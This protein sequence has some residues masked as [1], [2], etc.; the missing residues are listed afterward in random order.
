MRGGGGASFTT[1]DSLVIFTALARLSKTVLTSS[2]EFADL[3]QRSSDEMKGSKTPTATS[4][5]TLSGKRGWFRS[6]ESRRKSA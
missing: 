3:A 1:D 6:S 5:K 4:E 2:S